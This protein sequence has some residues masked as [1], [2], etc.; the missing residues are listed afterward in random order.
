MLIRIFI[1]NSAFKPKHTFNQRF[2]LITPT[3]YNKNFNKHEGEISCKRLPNIQDLKNRSS[4]MMKYCE[5][6]LSEGFNRI[7]MVLILVDTKN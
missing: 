6:Q 7:V 5:I 3:P 2:C 1:L 4:V